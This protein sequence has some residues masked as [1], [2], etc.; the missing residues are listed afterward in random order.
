M[1]CKTRLSLFMFCCA[2]TSVLPIISSCSNNKEQKQSLSQ[3]INET[4]LGDIPECT[5]TVITEKII[6]K[7]PNARFL[8]WSDITL[9]ISADQTK[10]VLQVK[11]KNTEFEGNVIVTFRVMDDQ[12]RFDFIA[13]RTISIAGSNSSYNK[14]T[15]GTGWLYKHIDVY[16]YY[17]FT[18]WHVSN[19]MSKIVG[20][21]YSISFEFGSSINGL[22]KYNAIAP[23]NPKWRNAEYSEDENGIKYGADA[24]MLEVD[25]STAPTA[26]K[27][28]LDK[29]NIYADEHD[30]LLFNG[31]ANYDN[32]EIGTEI[33][34]AGYPLA[35]Q[36][37]NGYSSATYYG[38]KTKI[39]SKTPYWDHIN[40]NEYGTFHSIDSYYTIISDVPTYLTEIGDLNDSTS[41]L[42][43]MGG[44]ASGSVSIDTNYN[45]VGL[46]WG[47]W[48]DRNDN[49]YRNSITPFAWGEHNLFNDL[50]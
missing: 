46:Y 1:S 24:S 47:G 9:S 6:S 26:Y 33:Y 28:R 12:A 3:I 43:N 38:D 44:G 45:I 39:C 16:K 37:K 25:F 18:N 11:P 50:I 31:I 49:T 4:S 21:N 13:E 36:N 17:M 14:D 7:N 2:F 32:I 5:V 29:I 40:T 15:F 35:S 34:V 41:V 20:F 42:W 19:S 48:I 27:N 22:A 30:G 23:I 8:P 10:C